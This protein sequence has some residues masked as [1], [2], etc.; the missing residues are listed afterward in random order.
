MLYLQSS[1]ILFHAL[2]VLHVFSLNMIPIALVYL[3]HTETK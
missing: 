1:L 3:L 2:A